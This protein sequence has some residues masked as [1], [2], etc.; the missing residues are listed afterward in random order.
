MEFLIKICMKYLSIVLSYFIFLHLSNEEIQYRDC[1]L[2][3]VWLITTKWE[4]CKGYF[5]KKVSINDGSND[6]NSKRIKVE[7]EAKNY[8]NKS[9]RER[10]LWDGQKRNYKCK[11]FS[12]CLRR[13]QKSGLLNMENTR[14]Y[15]LCIG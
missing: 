1:Y 6:I 13:Q 8:C 12:T 14:R 10:I 5:E 4:H 9:I 2:V 7:G 15:R 3:I 11:S